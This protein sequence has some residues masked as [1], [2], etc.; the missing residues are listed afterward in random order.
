M[1]NINRFV[2]PFWTILDTKDEVG[3]FVKK[4]F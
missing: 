1:L 4:V 3:I 2:V